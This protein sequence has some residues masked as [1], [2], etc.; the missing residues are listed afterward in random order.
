M[1]YK[2]GIIGLPN[3]GKSALFNRLT[4]LNVPSKNFPFCTIA[5]NLGMVSVI[6]NR[7]KKLALG[8]ESE[9]IVYSVVQLVDIA[10]L[11]KGASTGEGLGNRFLEKIRECHAVIHVTRCFKNDDIIHVYDAVDPARDIDIV[12]SELLLSDLDLCEKTVQRLLV[13][14]S[15]VH[16]RDDNTMNL[17][18]RCIQKLQLGVALRDIKFTHTELMYLKQ[19][20]FLTLKPMI[21]ALNMANNF[22]LNIDLKAFFK[23]I[24][25]NKLTIFPVIADAKDQNKRNNIDDLPCH[26]MSKQINDLNN[27]DKIVQVICHMLKLKTFFTAGPKETRSWLFRSGSTALQVASLI[28]SDFSKGFIRAQVISYDDFISLRSMYKIKK[29]G[30]LRSEGKKYL[31]N[32]G[33]IINFLFNV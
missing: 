22:D 1:V 21:Y 16:V 8:F 25:I 10:G 6:D 26:L 28:H 17:M 11:V 3:V 13:H 31:V 19:Y 32:D 2:F 9:K 30:K 29:F 23:N 15:Q 20:R 18:H 7:L 12:N 24:N 27:Y 33:D 5:P 14:K 4:K